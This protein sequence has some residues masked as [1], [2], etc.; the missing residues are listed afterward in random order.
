V[1]QWC[2]K[3]ATC[4]NQR[5][6]ALR[7]IKSRANGRKRQVEPHSNG[8][9]QLDGDWLTYYKVAKTY[10]SRV[11]AQDRDDIRHDI[12]IELD[13]AT[14]RDGKPLP[15]L[16]AYRIASLMVALYW[17]EQAKHQVKVCIYSGLPVEPHCARCSH[18]NGQRPC[19]YLALRPVQSL[20]DEASDDEGN[21][22]RLINTVA[23]DHAIDLEAWL[24]A[25]TWLLGCPMR[26]VK[27]AHKKLE[28]QPLD[29]KDKCYLQRFRQQEQKALF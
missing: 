14:K 24:D 19:P 20:D 25:K 29:N 17:R 18:H 26:L 13:R 23:D 1:C 16:R 21:G 10:E 6:Q 12:M 28:G 11:P 4:Q 22:V 15:L 2:G 8:Y 9:D 5:A 27:I 3:L 7:S